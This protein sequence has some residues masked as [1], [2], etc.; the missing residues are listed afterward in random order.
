MNYFTPTSRLLTQAGLSILEA[1]VTLVVISAGLLG[2]AGLQTTL[3]READVSRHRGEATRLAQE[4][5][6]TV[7]SYS[8]L[9]NASGVA[10][11]WDTFTWSTNFGWKDFPASGITVSELVPGINTTYTRQWTLGGTSD[12]PMRPLRVSVSWTDQYGIIPDSNINN[13]S[14]NE[15]I[16]DSIIAK[17][18]PVMSGGLNFPVAVSGASGMKMVKNRHMNIPY[19]ATNIGSD[20]SSYKLSSNYSIVF[21]NQYGSVVKECNTGTVTT[22]NVNT[23]C[24]P[25]AGYIVAGY[26]SR[27]SNSLSWPTGI[28]LATITGINSTTSKCNFG[29]AIDQNTLGTEISSYKYYIC[30][31]YLATDVEKWSGPVY[32][33]GLATTNTR[34]CRYQYTRAPGVTDNERNVQPE[35][36]PAQ[37]HLKGYQAVDMSL[38]NQNYIIV[39]ASQNC[40]AA[41]VAH[42]DMVIHQTC[43]TSTP[44]GYVRCPTSTAMF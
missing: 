10:I 33:G 28:S 12:D 21:D 22:E 23:A 25:M 8:Q 31:M 9:A 17:N 43:P 29:P 18:D 26:I 7:R 13:S 14:S 42:T 2:L 35:Y 34:V 11:T 6:E 38:D 1:L 36:S 32:L 24:T 30:L 3:T 15:I 19:P 16:L 5:I 39:G 40:P 41:S 27:N 37:A 4:R 20:Q 44:A